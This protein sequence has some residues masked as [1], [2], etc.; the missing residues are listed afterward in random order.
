MLLSKISQLPI[1]LADIIYLY[2]PLSTKQLLTPKKFN[3]HY[4]QKMKSMTFSEYS[5]HDSYIRDVVRTNRVFV[6]R[7]LISNAYLVWDRNKIWRWKNLKFPDYI[8]YLRYLSVKYKKP[9][10]K[11]IIEINKKYL[12]RKKP[13]KISSRNILWNS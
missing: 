9:Q 3:E 7:K 6:F 5:K 8:S 13:K 10:I 1:E 4:N 2:I 11:S 12:S